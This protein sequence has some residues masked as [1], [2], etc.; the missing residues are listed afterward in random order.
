VGATVG[1]SLYP[2]KVTGFG[3]PIPVTPD[4][5]PQPGEA[6][7]KIFEARCWL[8]NLLPNEGREASDDVPSSGGLV[9]LWTKCPHLGCAVPW[10]D[11]FVSDK[12]E[13]RRRGMF[14]CNCHGSTYTKAGTLVV[15]PAERAM[16]TMA[17]EVSEAGIV[18]QTGRITRG[19]Q[20]NPRRAV[21]YG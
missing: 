5:I 10:K 1:N 14:N 18:I 9:A 19:T 2:R 15:G 17:I 13:L 16:D 8:V 3:G 11:S 6:P 21:P 12:D 7:V 20:D 4:R